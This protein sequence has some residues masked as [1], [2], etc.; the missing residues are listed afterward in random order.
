MVCRVASAGILALLLCAALAGCGGRGGGGTS[1]GG[2]AP[3]PDG[4]V[5]RGTVTGGRPVAGAR[6]AF[7]SGFEVEA[8]DSIQPIE[9]LARTTDRA[10]TTD[11]R[12]AFSVTI[13][14]GPYFIVVIPPAGD[15]IHL[16]GG[17]FAQGHS[18]SLA[19]GATTV[20]NIE[21]SERPSG[22]ATFVGSS[23]CLSCHVGHASA[24][25]T[26]HFLG[27]RPV[28]AD[29]PQAGGLQ[30]LSGFPDANRAFAHFQDGN[31]QDNTGAD[32]DG[33]GYRVD[34]GTGYAVLL[35]RDAAGWF[36]ST[37][38]GTL[39]SSPYY[40][41][42]TYGGEGLYKQHFVTRIGADGA[43]TGDPS[44]GSY[45]LLPLEFDETKGDP[46]RGQEVTV[47]GWGTYLPERWAA[48]TAG[49]GSAARVPAMAQAFDAG[50]AGCHFT[51]MS[52]ARDGAGFFHAAA[53]A[54][55]GG[56]FDM[57]GD[58]RLEEINV[59]CERCHGP[60]SEHA[61]TAKGRIVQPAL[62]TADRATQVCAQCHLRGGG[63]AT[64]GGEFLGYPARGADDALQFPEAG[65]SPAEFYG[66]PDG[67][68]ILPDFGIDAPD[69]FYAP[70]DFATSDA[71]WKDRTGGFGS[72]A[73]HS[74][75]HQQQ[76]FDLQHARH[77]H[78]PWQIL[79]CF[80]CH[81][82]HGRAR[83]AQL[84]DRHDT[85]AL[86]LRCHATHGAFETVSARD[87][88][89]I[90]TGEAPPESVKRAVAA[91][92]RDE[93]F[94]LVGVSMNL[95]GDVYAN[96]SGYGGMGRCTVCHMPKTAKSAQWILDVEGFVIEGDIASHTFHTISPATSRGMAEAGRTPVP[97]SC[98]PCHRGLQ[99]GAWPDYRAKAR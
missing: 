9:D 66:T 1:T 77:A 34:A 5:V 12:G 68:R 91:H 86:C 48:P 55:A 63:E 8:L 26:L 95:P 96:P 46:R 59:G 67:A 17:T 18:L 69:G 72:A 76:S 74:A 78:N 47:P 65:M 4:S 29:G 80:D 30:D 14:P 24:R 25:G 61:A 71:S 53:V 41:L 49:G 39:V 62:L 94:A 43:Y 84:A 28:A 64:V 51:G 75:L 13:E 19:K 60:G 7:V 93:T 85:N 31:A 70:I 83:P 23:T 15:D 27:L 97:D 50:C 32:D 2:S 44:A 56:A 89:R 38:D 21:L 36:M 20:L 73:D 22:A 92:I 99:L 90:A 40:I 16:P 98:V 87:V 6:V 37:T 58:G 42:F 82:P 54:D 52:V 11:E 81:D 45:H 57:D 35:G 3:I 88:D 10:A 79:T 33:Y